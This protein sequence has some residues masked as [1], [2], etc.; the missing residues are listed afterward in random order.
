MITVF[1]NW[2]FSKKMLVTFLA[3]GALMG[4]LAGSGIIVMR[5]LE[6]IATRHVERGIAGTDALGRLMT[7]LREHRVIILS[8]MNARSP[9]QERNYAERFDKNRQAIDR[10]A[11]DYAPLAGEFTPQLSSLKSRIDRLHEVNSRI[12][13]MKQRSGAEAA[14]AMILGEGKDISDAAS[15][16]ANDLIAL[17]KARAKAS[18]DTGKAFAQRA[19][20]FILAVTAIGMAGLFAIWRL[21]ARSVSA[22]L[23]ELSRTTT[24]LA[25][26][27][28]ARVPSLDRGDELGDVA[29]AVEQFRM[30]AVNRAEADAA[31]AR[32]QQ[33]IT[34]ALRDGLAALSE[35]DLTARIQAEFPADYAELKT[36]FNE[37]LSTLGTLIAAVGQSTEAIR[38][39]SGEI[40]Q[41]SEDLARRTESSAASL[42]QTAAAVTQMDGRLKATAV[43]ATRTVERADGAISTVRG[44]R[45]TAHEAVEAMTR[46]ADS[47][48]GIDSV[49][50]GLDK[51]A[52]QTRVLA[53]NAA[54]E[55]GR[56]GEAGRGFA[57]V[58]DL[59]SAL[60]MRAE[61]EAGR[62]RD[63][64]TTTQSEIVSAVE[65]VRHVDEAL[66][67]ITSD[68]EEVHGLLGSMAADNQAQSTAI[69]QISVAI[70]TM[71]QSTQQNAAMVEETSAA[72][73]NLSNEVMTLAGQTASFK[74]AASAT[75][76]RPRSFEAKKP[77]PARVSGNAHLR[78]L[79]AQVP[80]EADW[81]DF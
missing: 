12:F 6:A 68:V 69:S 36:N 76:P 50:E 59:V 19:F 74:V 18:N 77:R 79:S 35:G 56:A 22:P 14:L 71:D 75:P 30:A 51:I 64:L 38:T 10:A 47:A 42:E 58:A 46:V 41:A 66:A 32:A 31:A 72:A 39:G 29:K 54:V 23:A 24:T 70:G 81:N 2:Q 4:T 63:Q 73:R 40:A 49:I 48:K 26:G 3:I 20:W 45:E 43:S 28:T 57:V 9:E 44:G 67:A 62:A 61:E 60:A 65:M 13:A 52:F 37:A 78:L 11:S 17:Q 53:M 16:E 27:G 55:A 21:L 8:Q 34:S 80:S 1:N 33:V 25:E 5:E 15:K 7:G